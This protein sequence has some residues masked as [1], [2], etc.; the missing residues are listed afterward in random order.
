LMQNAANDIETSDGSKST[1]WIKSESENLLAA[2]DGALNS[3]NEEVLTSGIYL[4]EGLEH[5]WFPYCHYSEARKYLDLAL[6]EIKERGRDISKAIIYGMKG[7]LCW[8]YLDLQGGIDFHRMSAELLEALGDEKRLA[9]AL[10]NLAANLDFANQ[11]EEAEPHYVKSLALSRKMGDTWN[12]L[13]VLSNFGNRNQEIRINLES[14]NNHLRQALALARKLGRNYEFSIIQFNLACLYYSK[15][16]LPISISLLEETIQIADENRYLQVMAFTRG[17]LGR[18]ALDQKKPSFAA[19]LLDEA[20]ELSIL[21]NFQALSYEIVEVIAELCIFNRRYEEAVILYEYTSR[22]LSGEAASRVI[23]FSDA[24]KDQYKRARM[25]LGSEK[26]ESS[27]QKGQLINLTEIYSLAVSV[28]R[29]T[30]TKT[31]SGNAGVQFTERE[32]E[33]LGLLA[34]GK[35]NEDISKEL[36]VV[37]KTVEKHVANVLRKL[38]V[39]NRTE[40]A[41]W[42]LENGIK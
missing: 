12:E 28:C 10:N 13:R 22:E 16:D 18:I 20:L 30:E 40:A 34:Q 35:T 3:E 39:K 24:R 27:R 5:Y 33:V 31:K 36:V 42:A 7:T 19:S 21:S 41:A 8:S 14:A 38:G 37:L 29:P 6:Q 4:M 23:P 9:R 1:A 15:G 2:L 32:M 11:V 17:L 25:E 26:F